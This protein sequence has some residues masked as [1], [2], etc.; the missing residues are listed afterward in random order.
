[1]SQ[2]DAPD[3]NVKKVVLALLQ[4]YP[5]EVKDA[6]S[7]A[8]PTSVNQTTGLCKIVKKTIRPQGA[9]NWMVEELAA[10]LKKHFT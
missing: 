10:I 4:G 8:F 3:P 7:Q 9:R 2:Q 5:D 1:M 6:V